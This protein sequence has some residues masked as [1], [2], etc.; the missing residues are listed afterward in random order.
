MFKNK[1]EKGTF[2]FLIKEAIVNNIF[3][4][5]CIYLPFVF[6]LLHELGKSLSYFPPEWHRFVDL[7]LEA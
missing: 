3:D 1:N 5:G 2:Y 4:L 7:N 6:L